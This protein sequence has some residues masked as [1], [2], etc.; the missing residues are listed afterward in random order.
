MRHQQKATLNNVSCSP[1]IPK[2]E[3]VHTGETGSEPRCLGDTTRT[4]R[5]TR[6]QTRLKETHQ[7]PSDNNGA[8]HSQW[9]GGRKRDQNESSNNTRQSLPKALGTNNFSCTDQTTCLL[10]TI[11]PHQHDMAIHCNTE[12]RSWQFMPRR[13]FW[14]YAEQILRAPVRSPHHRVAGHREDHEALRATCHPVPRG[15]CA[16]LWHVAADATPQTQSV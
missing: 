4:S 13:A 16:P 3:P 5:R 7:P 2:K 14:R 6:R 10:F 11:W 9:H 15:V 12:K 1:S 8:K